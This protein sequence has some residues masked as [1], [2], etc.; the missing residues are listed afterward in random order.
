LCVA[1]NAAIAG[2]ASPVGTFEDHAD[3]GKPA[4]A[5]SAEFDAGNGTYTVSGGGANMWAKADAFQFVWK[6]MSGDVTIAADIRFPNP[7]GNAHRKACL[8]IRQSLDADSAYVDA[9]VHGEGLTSLQ[10]RD[11]A[12]ETTHEIQ[13]NIKQPLRVRLEKQGDTF[14]MS[15]AREGESLQRAGGTIKVKLAEPFYVG[16][17]VCAH[18]DAAIEKAQFVN[19]QITNEKFQLNAKPKVESTLET[20]AVASTDCRVV[21]RAASHFEAPNWTP[22]GKF[23][24]FNSAGR[25]YRLPREGGQPEQIDTGNLDRCNNDHG[26]SFDGT[27][28]AISHAVA[29]KSLIYVLPI[30][31][32][33]PRQ[34]T[35]VGPSYWHGW[36]PDGKTLAY[37]AQRNGEFDIYTIPAA[38]GEEKRLTDAKGLDDGPEYTP[39]GKYIYFNSIR[40]GSMQVWRMK[41]DGSQ[42]EQVTS[43]EYN[44][45]FPHVSPDGKLIVFLSYEK[46]VKEHPANKDVLL[47]LMP[48]G[49]GPVRFLAK[50]FGGQGTIN[51]PSWSPD[52][53]NVAFV[54]YQLVNP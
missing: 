43:D 53:R 24:L 45:W 12:G 38:G 47:R 54:S 33:T 10:Y 28:L 4:K 27:Q 42:Q 2:A 40:G 49:G 16:L 11:A 51:V 36:S 30:A 41:S 25:I 37:C 48:I 50:V 13:A 21:Y 3:V 39:D 22:D 1:M 35:P 34:L 26:I 8:V 17:G 46:D 52:S 5:G 20:V 7:G 9:A 15:F 14:F 29:G 6:R 31:G 23:F 19:V 18:D 44:N 32:G